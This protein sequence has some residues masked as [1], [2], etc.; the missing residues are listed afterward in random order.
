MLLFFVRFLKWNKFFFDIPSNPPPI[1][2]RNSLTNK[3]FQKK[4][5]V[6][7]YFQNKIIRTSWWFLTICP[8]TFS[9]SINF[10]LFFFFIVFWPQVSNFFMQFLVG[11][12]KIDLSK[13][14]KL[15]FCKCCSS[16]ILTSPK[17]GCYNGLRVLAYRYWV[18]SGPKGSVPKKKKFKM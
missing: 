10:F 7:V 3:F 9:E 5:D 12:T 15:I 1:P 11:H 17:L 14:E 8:N 4:I 13:T 6:S 16:K 18:D 2:V